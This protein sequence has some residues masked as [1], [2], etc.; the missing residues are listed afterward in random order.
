MEIANIV[1]KC[2]GIVKEVT[3]GATKDEGG[4][5]G[6]V[7]TIGGANSIL[8]WILTEAL[9]ISRRLQW[10]YTMYHRKSGLNRL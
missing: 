6:R 8:L 9:D 3:I 5:R 4:T 1:D 10:T 2:A 7:V